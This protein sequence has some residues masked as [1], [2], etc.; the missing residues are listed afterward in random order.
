MLAD[1]HAA[2]RLTAGQAEAYGQLH[3]R[4]RTLLSPDRQ[5]T[6]ALHAG[7]QLRVELGHHRQ[8]E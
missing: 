8:S 6:E 5:R 4:S 7:P 3:G 1:P 2:E